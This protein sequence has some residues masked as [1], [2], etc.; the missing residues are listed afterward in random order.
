MALTKI[1]SEVW[2]AETQ[3]S[4]KKNLVFAAP[5][6]CNRDYTGDIAD[7][8]DIVH[9][10]NVSDPTVGAYTA[11]SDITIQALTDAETLLTID[12]ANYFGFQVDDV[13]ARQAKNINSLI[14]EATAQASYKLRD[15]ADSYVA[16]AMKNDAL[17]GNKLG[18][19]SVNS[20]DT[21]FKLLVD[22]RTKLNQSNVPFDGRWAVVTPELEAYFV[23]DSRFINAQAYGSTDPIQNGR[24][25]RALGFDI[26]VS[27]NCAAGASTGKIVVAG[28]PGAVTYAEQIAKVETGRMEKRFADFVK[29]LHLFGAKVVRPAG[30]ATADVTVS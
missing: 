21:A 3:V 8:G 26:Y 4:L 22:L 9:I 19:K 29:G 7:Q 27:N 5:S 20:A 10:I 30:L 6:V 13:H 15:T 17:S 12:Q 14:G 25:G 18:A 24:I 23:Q 16:T 1:Q 11:D 28:Y 2:A